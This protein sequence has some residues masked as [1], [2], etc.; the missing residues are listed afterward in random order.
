MSTRGVLQKYNMKSLKEQKSG[1]SLGKQKT[2]YKVKGSSKFTDE[3]LIT[4]KNIASP[5]QSLEKSDSVSVSSQDNSRI[6]SG[7]PT[8]ANSPTSYSSSMVSIQDEPGDIYEALEKVPDDGRILEHDLH[9]LN[10]AIHPEPFGV[11]GYQKFG[12]DGKYEYYVVRA[13]VRNAR[14][15][16]IKA[17]DKSFSR[18]GADNA[19]VEMEQRYID[20]NPSW[21]FEKAFRTLKEKI[22][23][24]KTHFCGYEESPESSNVENKRVENQINR[25]DCST[26]MLSDIGS[27]TVDINKE[28]IVSG[29]KRNNNRLQF[30]HGKNI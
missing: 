9:L 1:T 10:K 24:C 25:N 5:T 8:A 6:E 23:T 19:P 21:M 4:S 15:I 13:W 11:L 7:V 17:I 27:E 14:R 2:E 3:V 12:D 18:I 20:G 16:Q 30:N 29:K 26:N 28:K 22:P